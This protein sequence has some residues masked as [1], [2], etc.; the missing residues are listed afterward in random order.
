[1]STKAKEAAGKKAAEL[2]KNGMTVGLGTGSTA[3]YFIKALGVRCREGLSIKAV[4]TSLES[5]NLANKEN[6]PLTDLQ[7]LDVIDI[8]VDGADEIDPQKRMIKGGGG[9][10]FR[11]KIVAAMSK[12]MVVIIDPSKQVDALGKF[13]L[14]VEISPFAYRATLHHIHAMGYQGEMRLNSNNTFFMTDNGNYI[15]DID[16]DHPCT[17]PEIVEHQLSATPGLIDTGFFL[18][19]AGRVIIGQENGKTITLD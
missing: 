10:L 3:F 8:D 4:A 5:E 12:E 2:I 6:I 14:P 9:A 17:T 19:I 16:L 13:P 18:G 15:Y 7:K 1:M 11:E